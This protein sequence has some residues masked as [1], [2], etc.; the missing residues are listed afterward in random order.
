MH[1]YILDHSA[2]WQIWLGALCTL[3]IYTI[4]YRENKIYRFFEHL[5]IGLATGWAIRAA[6]VDV[7]RPTWWDRMVIEGRWW[8]FFTLPLGLLMYLIYTKKYNWMARITIGILLGL[9]AGQQ[10][11]QFSGLYYKQIDTTFKP[12]I[13]QA[14]QAA[15]ATHAAVKEVSLSGAVNNLLFLAILICVMT[16]FF[17][18]FEQKNKFVRN[19]A[20]T[21]R[22]VLMVAFG[23]IFGSTI[24][25]RMALFISRIDWMMHTWL[26]IVP[27]IG[28][29]FKQ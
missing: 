5:F 26:P 11:Q 1:Q 2:S 7:L 28:D 25:A 12:I 9:N 18:S 24:M 21:G 3:G 23:A 14:A 10:F 15:T 16:Y 8:W 20:A 13:P 27:G 22:W 17:F 4:L 6:W 19:T 29:W